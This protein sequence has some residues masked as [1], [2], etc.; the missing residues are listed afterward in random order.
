MQRQEI[1][2]I[3]LSLSVNDN[4]NDEVGIT[5]TVQSYKTFFILNSIGK[6]TRQII[7]SITFDCNKSNKNVILYW[8]RVND[9]CLNSKNVPSNKLG[10]TWYCNG[11]STLLISI[12]SKYCMVHNAHYT[13]YFYK[14]HQM[15]RIPYPFTQQDNLLQSK[16]FKNIF[17]IQ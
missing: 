1:V 16:M 3:Y 5:Y 2:N 6:K 17:S 4:N 7:A 11:F 10:T 13:K 9:Y 8:L 14:C 15:I 12:V